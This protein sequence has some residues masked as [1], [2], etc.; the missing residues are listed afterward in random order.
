MMA[1]PYKKG[2]LQKQVCLGNMCAQ[3]H[4]VSFQF[5]IS[6]HF[7]CA[8]IL[9]RNDQKWFAVKSPFFLVT[10]LF[11][12]MFAA[13][14]IHQVVCFGDAETVGAKM[15]TFSGTAHINQMWYHILWLGT[16][17]TIQEAE[18]LKTKD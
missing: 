11:K 3:P 13:F 10:K 12:T 14:V 6:T 7:S 9:I 1:K 18:A 2:G 4:L 17:A 8:Q 5:C 16:P 15:K